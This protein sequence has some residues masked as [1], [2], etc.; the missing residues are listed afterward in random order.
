MLEELFEALSHAWQQLLCSLGFA[1]KSATIL[2]LGL[3]N[4]GKTTMLYKLKSGTVQSFVPTQRPQEQ[5]VTIGGL[6]LRAWDVGGHMRVRGMWEQYFGMADAIVF[7]VDAAD[8]ARLAEAATELRKL[9]DEPEIG[10]API[11]V[12]ANKSDVSGAL[13]RHALARGLGIERNVGSRIG[14]FESSLVRGTGYPEAFSWLA[15]HF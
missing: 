9:I 4:A 11:A 5:T 13:D 2:L 6:N 8:K 3:D 12:L 10:E 7:M 15:D 1:N 14:V